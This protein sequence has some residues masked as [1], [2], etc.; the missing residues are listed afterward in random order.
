KSPTLF[1]GFRFAEGG[2]S[3]REQLDETGKI[4]T[5]GILFSSGSHKIKGESYKTLK[6]IGNLLTDDPEL[7][8]LIEGH[9]DS[10]GADDYNM[11]LSQRRAESVRSYLIN[12]YGIAGERLEAKGWGESKP[13]DTNNSPEGKANNRRVELVKL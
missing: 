1:R 8:L 6:N 3:L 7:R 5:H 9:T 11:N 13:I 12:E 10:D 4:V 2:K